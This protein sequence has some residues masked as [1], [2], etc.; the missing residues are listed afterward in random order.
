MTANGMEQH[1]ASVD[2][3]PIHERNYNGFLTILKRSAL[4]VAIVSAIVI[5]IISR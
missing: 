4:A 1:D 3:F 5:F 2:D